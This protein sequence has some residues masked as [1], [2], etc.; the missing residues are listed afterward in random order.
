VD[1]ALDERDGSWVDE[2]DPHD[3][4]G[5]ESVVEIAASK[6]KGKAPETW[7]GMSPHLILPTSLADLERGVIA[8]TRK[9]KASFDQAGLAVKRHKGIH[10]N[11]GEP[12]L[13]EDAGNALCSL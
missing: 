5:D 1:E 4:D 11:P 7:S 8:A 6:L 9:R 12:N 13:V 3:S 10:S 2:S